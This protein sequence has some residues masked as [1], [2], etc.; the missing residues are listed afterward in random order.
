[1]GLAAPDIELV[2]PPPD[3]EHVAVTVTIVLPPSAAGAVKATEAD[4]FPGITFRMIGAS[5]AEA[6]DRVSDSCVGTSLLYAYPT[7]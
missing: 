3:E 4:P 7:A 5:G 6:P 2:A 1:M